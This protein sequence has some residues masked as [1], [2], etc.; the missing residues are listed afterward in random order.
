MESVTQDQM[1]M[2]SAIVS[3]HF[4]DLGVTLVRCHVFEMKY[5]ALEL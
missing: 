2:E 5:H 3:H 1:A 4:Q